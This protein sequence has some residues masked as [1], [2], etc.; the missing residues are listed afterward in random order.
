VGHSPGVH[1][2]MASGNRGGG[3]AGGLTGADLSKEFQKVTMVSEDTALHRR[4]WF[5]FSTVR[6]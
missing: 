1:D 6:S 3:L 4:R 2:G 5:L